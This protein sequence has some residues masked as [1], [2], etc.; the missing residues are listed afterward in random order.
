MSLRRTD[1][2]ELLTALHDGL[3]EQPRWH[4]FVERLRRRTQAD[5]A[6]LIVGRGG[7]PIQ[8]AAE[9]RA[10]RDIRSALGELDDYVRR[11]S[12]NYD[13]LRSGRVYAPEDL[14]DAQIVRHDRYRQEYLQRIGAGYSRIMRVAAGDLNA[15]I[16]IA[17]AQQD[18]GA[19]DGTLLS[20]LAPHL[21]I[22]IRNL[23]ALEREALR[24]D[25]A[26]RLLDRAGIRLA[27]GRDPGSGEAKLDLT[28]ALDGPPR[29]TVDNEISIAVAR[30]ARLLSKAQLRL[31]A[32][33]HDLPP[34]EARLALLLASGHSIAEAAAAMGL[35]IET[36]RNYSKRLYGK[37]GTRGQGELVAFVLGSPAMLA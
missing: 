11:G 17:R 6:S 22:A 23:A 14:I 26:E 19:E 36:A 37:T 2:T 34:S 31:F 8:H 10:G 12:V 5:Y 9:T 20:A 15:W 16:A 32:E 24:A 33:L 1:E 7:V 27:A 35:T 25:I 21:A 3:E 4:N 29:A 13:T 28:I 30:T 18:F